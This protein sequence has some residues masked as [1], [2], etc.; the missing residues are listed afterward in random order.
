MAEFVMEHWGSNNE[1]YRGKMVSEER[2]PKLSLSAA[3]WW[4]QGSMVAVSK[5]DHCSSMRRYVASCEHLTYSLWATD[6]GFDKYLVTSP[7]KSICICIWLIIWSLKSY[8]S[9]LI[10]ISKCNVRYLCM[11]V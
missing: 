7:I 10:H 8:A 3:V 11:Q 6:V 9:L 2:Q 1:E 5:F 4:V